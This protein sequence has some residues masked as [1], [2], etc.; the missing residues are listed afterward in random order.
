MMASSQNQYMP[1]GGY[2]NVMGN[3]FDL[4]ANANKKG[5]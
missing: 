2:I 4:K 5:Q 3:N 1:Y